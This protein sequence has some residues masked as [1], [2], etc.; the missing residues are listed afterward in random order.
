MRLTVPV[1][2]PIKSGRRVLTASAAAVALAISIAG[3]APAAQAGIR[4]CAWQPLT[5]QNGWQSEQTVYQTGDPSYCAASDGMVYLSGSLALPAG[6]SFIPFATLPSYAAP[7]HTEFMSVYTYNGTPGTLEVDTN[8]SLRAYFGNAT[9]FTSLAGVSF[10]AAGTATLGVM[11]LLNG[12]QSAQSTWGTGDPSYFIS[13][14]AVHLDGSV[15]NPT[16]HVP[17]TN[18]GEFMQLPAGAKPASWPVVCFNR[19]VYTDGGG[20]GLMSNDSFNPAVFAAPSTYFTSLAGVSY[21]LPSTTWQPLTSTAA[22]CLGLEYSII[23]GVVYLTGWMQFNQGFT[24]QIAVLPTGARPAHVLY[25]I[26]GGDG[27]GGTQ[28]VT[29]QINPNGVVSVSNGGAVD[30]YNPN[31]NSPGFNVYPAGTS[32]HINS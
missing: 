21:P 11:P 5:L 17:W 8:G 13:G 14:G 6:N 9:Q 18:D 23:S 24:G 29:M 4:G 15:L 16:P 7:A 2:G 28:W 30:L 19:P 12:W 32:Y 26:V 3:G 27:T 22:S 1:K 10:P 25:L 20:T 31:N